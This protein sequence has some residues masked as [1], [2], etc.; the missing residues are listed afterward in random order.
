MDQLEVNQLKLMK[1]IRD[2]GNW[3]Q[4][5]IGVNGV[6]MSCSKGQKTFKHDNRVERG[7]SLLC[8]SLF[9]KAMEG[10]Q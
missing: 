5:R 2:V 9:S 3:S 8:K 10:K 1:M 7:T 4:L 6:N